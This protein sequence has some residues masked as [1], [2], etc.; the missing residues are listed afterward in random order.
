M[1]VLNSLIREADRR[2]ALSPLPGTVIA[3]RASLYAADLVVL[4]APTQPDLLCIRHILELFAG[5]SRLV[6]NVEKCIVKLIRCSDETV[7]AVQQ[8][9]PSPEDIWAFHYC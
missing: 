3:H 9:C 8:T 4:L 5:A 2:A 6:T 7:A 1:E